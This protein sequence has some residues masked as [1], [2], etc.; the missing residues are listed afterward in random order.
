MAEGEAADTV[1]VE[2]EVIQGAVAAASTWVAAAVVVEVCMSAGAVAHPA[3]FTSVVVRQVECTLAEAARRVV[4]MLVA[5]VLHKGADPLSAGHH[6]W[7]ISQ[8]GIQT[9]AVR[10]IQRFT[11]IFPKTITGNTT[12]IGSTT[13]TFTITSSAIRSTLGI[14]TS[15]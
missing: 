9:M 13:G 15:S 7:V 11:T 3:G 8:V 10:E 6:K 4:S 5:A 1:V 12:T 14:E 2:G